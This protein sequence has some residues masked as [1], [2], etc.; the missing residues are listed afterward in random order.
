[1]I[2]WR[3]L[4]AV[5]LVPSLAPAFGIVGNGCKVCGLPAVI[6]REIRRTPLRCQG[7]NAASICVP[8]GIGAHRSSKNRNILPANHD[9]FAGWRP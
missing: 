1:M 7:T 3:P 9:R 4:L 2:L 5:I 6:K 8:V